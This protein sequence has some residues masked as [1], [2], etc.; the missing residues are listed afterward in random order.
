MR[1][2][3][4]TAILLL[5]ACNAAPLNLEATVAAAIAMT[6]T[7]LAPTPSPSATP[8][9]A[10]TATDT[11]APTPTPTETPLPTRIAGAKPI[12]LGETLS[13]Y[14][15][16]E[17]WI[18]MLDA[19][20][21]DEVVVTVNATNLNPSWDYCKAG[22][23]ISTPYSLKTDSLQQIEAIPTGGN[24]VGSTYLLPYT[25]WYYIT[26]SCQGEWCKGS[27]AQVDTSLALA[28]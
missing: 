28:P 22:A 21:G 8:T 26:V 7:A 1:R 27:C 2:I 17:S 14:P 23:R 20:K 19:H 15:R 11:P 5:T 6:D 9:A 16:G 4:V 24:A 25:G 3:G 12:N 18:Y 13:Y 10:P